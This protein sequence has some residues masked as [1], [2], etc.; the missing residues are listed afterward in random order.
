VT[1]NIDEA[2]T[3]AVLLD[4]EG[5]TTPL[6]FVREVLFPYA[7]ARVE[8]YFHGQPQSAAVIQD[9]EALQREHAADIERGLSPPAWR[10]E[11]LAS[12]PDSATAYVHWLM[13]Q[14]R[15]ST[16]LKSIQGRIWEAGY[17]SRELRGLVYPDVGPAFLRWS[18]NGKQIFIFSSGSVLAQ[19]LLFEST[20]EGDLTRFIAS[21]FDTTTGPKVRPESYKQIA[22]QI[23]LSPSGVLFVSDTSAELDAALSSGMQVVLCARSGRSQ[24]SNENYPIADTLDPILP[25]REGDAP[26]TAFSNAS[27]SKS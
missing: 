9:L 7:R 27:L 23:G 4:I 24:T 12:Q 21:Y 14:D 26:G 16:A 17:R 3:R 11:S 6:E 2:R 8:G 18:K 25:E 22:G 13:D 5:T 20:P 1:L 15:K 19:R 10:A